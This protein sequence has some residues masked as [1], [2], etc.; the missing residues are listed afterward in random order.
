MEIIWTPEARSSFD[1]IVDFINRKFTL[2]EVDHFI[3]ETLDVLD[4]LKNYPELF[5]KS[6]LK[7]L[8]SARKAVIHPHSSVFYVVN[9]ETI[10][11]LLFW[12]NRR[13]PKKRWT[14]FC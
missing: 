1:E 4:S 13:D 5:P 6:I 8:K 11:I 12:D 7:A 9:G 2:K 14:N 3:T 10:T